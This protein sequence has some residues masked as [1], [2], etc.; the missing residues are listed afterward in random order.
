MSRRYVYAVVDHWIDM[1]GYGVAALCE[2][3]AAA[4]RRA[5]KMNGSH[6]CDRYVVR[7]LPVYTSATR[8]A[9]RTTR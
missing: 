3:K 8:K 2:I 5:V 1:N 4:T 9:K 6:G 7:R